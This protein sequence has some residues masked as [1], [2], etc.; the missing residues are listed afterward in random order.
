MNELRKFLGGA[1]GVTALLLAWGIF[2]ATRTSLHRGPVHVH[3]FAAESLLIIAVLV[4]AVAA[5]A[6]L[7][8]RRAA[9][10]LGLIASLSP[11]L[12]LLAIIW[13][14]HVRIGGVPWIALGLAIAGL[15]AFLPRSTPA[16]PE[17]RPIGALQGD[18]T[19][20]WV[21]VSIWILGTIGFLVA[22]NWWWR[23]AH[24]HGLTVDNGASFYLQLV[25]VDLII[26]LVHEL[27]HTF[28]GLAL[29]MKLR[30]FIIGPFQWRIRDGKWGFQFRPAGFF[31]SGGATALVP[32]A[33]RQPVANQVC[34]IAAGPFASFVS[35][36][37][38]LCAALTA[39]GRPWEP[40]WFLLACVATLSLIVGAL[41]LVPFQTGTTYS[42]G[43]QIYQLLSGGAW[44]DYHRAMAVVTS[45]LVTPLRP[46]DYD[47]AVMQRAVV[48]IRTGNRAM[49]LHL[50]ISSYYMDRSEFSEAAFALGQAERVYQESAPNIPAE[51]HTAFVFRKALLER[52]A[53][54]TRQWW[55]RMEAKKPTHFNVDYW[56]ACGALLWVEKNLDEARSALEKADAHAQKLPKFGAYEFDRYL[57]DLLRKAL[58]E[59][60]AA[61][62]SRL[63]SDTAAAPA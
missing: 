46:R 44:A 10:S 13:H 53:V 8:N 48:G 56:L 57:C 50:N 58:D 51:L 3:S 26:V 19:N 6:I 38:A 43:A 52:D 14:F 31:S 39:P 55:D 23:W 49:L 15:V 24:L 32:T 20:K 37:I 42:D 27:G 2:S 47:I 34:M 28:T 59:S 40:A 7:M 11:L 45:T 9:R 54:G 18:G 17:S 21:G 61:L 5:W 16:K 30:A 33:P 25:L 62:A 12:V 22:V 35:G 36:I 1:F 63:L 29:G 41:N 4:N 60:S